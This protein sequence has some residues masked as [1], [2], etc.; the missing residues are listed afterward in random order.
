MTASTSTATEHP[1]TDVAAYLRDQRLFA[2][3]E[4]GIVRLPMLISGRLVVPSEITADDALAAL[5]GAEYAQT[6][7]VQI[8]RQALMD[9]QTLRE[10]GRHLLFVLPRVRDVDE[11]CATTADDVARDLACLPTADIGRYLD[12]VGGV[13]APGG[14]LYYCLRSLVELT[15]DTPI[16]YLDA[17][18]SGLALAFDGATVLGA[19]DRELALGTTPG[20]ELLDSWVA[21]AGLSDTPGLTGQLSGAVHDDAPLPTPAPVQVRAMPTRQLHITA[22]NSPMIPVISAV[23]GLGVKGAVTLKMPAG[24]LAAGAALAAALYFAGPR[25]PLTRHASV[26]YWRG[27]DRQVEQRLFAPGAFDRIVAWGAPVAVDSVRTQAGLTKTLTFNPRYGASMIGAAALTPDVFEETVRRAATDALVWNQKA[28]IAS[29]VQYVEGDRDRVDAYAA[30]LAT[31]LAL[32]DERLPS[33]V[34]AELVGRVRQAR[35]SGM[36]HGRWL[37]NGDRRAP[38]SAVVVLDA[39]FDLATHPASRVIA[40]RPV[41]QLE[42]ALDTFHPGVSEVGIAPEARRVELRDRVCARG[43]TGVPPLGNADAVD[44]AGIPQDGIRAMAELVS[45]VTA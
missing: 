1:I 3:D 16:A 19:V 36:R 15:A 20:R 14:S 27:G 38:A 42:D 28:C 18:L 44:I 5:G 29:L 9:P 39:A 43:V 32:W 41:A 21:P 4:H 2:V 40:V 31:E 45:W 34:P 26:V 35:R 33:P 8:V 6:D 25:H 24:A 11:L 13:L 12:R 22:G 30:A 23:R 10:D 7:D 17:A 37:A